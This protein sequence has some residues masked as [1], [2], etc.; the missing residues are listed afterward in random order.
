MGRDLTVATVP[1]DPNRL[2]R[3]RN[4]VFRGTVVTRVGRL[5]RPGSPRFDPLYSKPG[6]VEYE[7]VELA[8]RCRLQITLGEPTLNPRNGEF[9]NLVQQTARLADAHCIRQNTN[10]GIPIDGGISAGHWSGCSSS[11]SAIFNICSRVYSRDLSPLVR[12]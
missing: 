4:V 1:T 3:F 8:D 11:A 12:R 6:L 10:L 2:W 7:P 9:G 5:N